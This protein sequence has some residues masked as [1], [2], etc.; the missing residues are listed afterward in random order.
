VIRICADATFLVAGRR[1]GLQYAR[2]RPLENPSSL[3]MSQLPKS[4]SPWRRTDPWRT[5]IGRRRGAAAG[6]ALRL[7]SRSIG[8]G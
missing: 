8:R 5:P 1:A 6:A 3:R 7:R 4:A 2:A